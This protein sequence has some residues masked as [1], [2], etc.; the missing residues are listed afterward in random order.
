MELNRVQEGLLSRK[1]LQYPE[2]SVV[3]MEVWFHNL[4]F[5][6]EWMVL[7]WAESRRRFPWERLHLFDIPP[8][9]VHH[10]GD[11]EGHKV[12]GHRSRRLLEEEMTDTFADSLRH[13]NR[14]YTKAYGHAIRKV[15]SHMPHY[16]QKDVMIE[17]Q[18][19]F[20]TQYDITSS[21]PV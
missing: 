11:A 6:Q 7:G 5:V 13:V 18:D 9:S 12:V 21:H 19:K 14:L 1:L 8:S 2:V 17:L 3:W 20:A 10:Q 4:Q 15:P 16:I